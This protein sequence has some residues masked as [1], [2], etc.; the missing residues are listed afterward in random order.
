MALEKAGAGQ[1][2]EAPAFLKLGN[3]VIRGL[4]QCLDAAERPSGNS[5]QQKEFGQL[6]GAPKSTI[7][8]WYHGEVPDPI[9]FF[10]CAL[11]RLKDTE[12]SE[13]LTRLCRPC[14]RLDHPRLS[15]NLNLIQ[16]LDSL[17][18]AP[19]GLSFLV[20]SSDSLRQFVSAAIG[21][22][23]VRTFPLS[24]IRG[25]DLRLPDQWAPV[26]GVTYFRT[27]TN[28]ADLKNAILQ[29][30]DPCRYSHADFLLF[31]HVW[32][33]VPELH[34]GIAELA[35][36]KTVIVGDN[37]ASG[38]QGRKPYLAQANIITMAAGPNGRIDLRIS[39]RK[40][41]GSRN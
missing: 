40:E 33:M 26:P 31:D 21:N 30:W 11:E 17:R 7:H 10:L 4:K 15:H 14:I 24:R 2:L 12:R 18:T 35:K 8:D 41:S 38:L 34:Q 19:A 20:G 39:L 25:L 16:W 37:Y 27:R 23:A 29:Y 3:E 13:L 5:L 1:I 9:T 6:L 22:S 36:T 32:E 28:I